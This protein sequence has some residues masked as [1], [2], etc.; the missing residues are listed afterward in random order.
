MTSSSE[1]VDAVAASEAGL[2]GLL[3]DLI[4]FRT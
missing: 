1:V 4:A 2:Q 3:R